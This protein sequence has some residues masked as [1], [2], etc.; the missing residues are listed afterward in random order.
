[1]VIVPALK[2]SITEL[3]ITVAKIRLEVWLLQ[4]FI[5]NMQKLINI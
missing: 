3:T 1:M 2:L 4:S 5:V